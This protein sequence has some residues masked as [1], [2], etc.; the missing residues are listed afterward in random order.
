MT[1]A[2]PGTSDHNGLSPRQELLLRVLRD[3]TTELS[4]QALHSALAQ[5]QQRLGLATVYRQ[6]R[7][8]QRQGLVRCRQLP[9]GESLFAPL[10]RD[11]HHLTCVDCGTS[12]TLPICPMGHQHLPPELLGNFRP[13]FHTLEFYGICGNCQ[14]DTTAMHT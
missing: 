4:G 2:R 6:L 12:V 11:E 7:Q 13:L 3:S 14:G 9:N 10:E 5:G 1:D 8:L